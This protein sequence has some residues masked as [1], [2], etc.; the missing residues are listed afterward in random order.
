MKVFSKTLVFLPSFS[1]D[2]LSLHFYC[3]YILFCSLSYITHT[4]Q[5]HRYFYKL[6]KYVHYRNHDP[7]PLNTLIVVPPGWLSQWSVCLWLRSW[8]W[9][10][11]IESYIRLPAQWGVCFSLSTCPSLTFLHSLSLKLL[12]SYKKT[13]FDT[14]KKNMQ[15]DNQSAFNNT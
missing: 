2:T 8:S 14:Q 12:K 9:D 1:L 15:L 11:R 10:P 5:S 13:Y 6:I 3:F 4:T 7:F